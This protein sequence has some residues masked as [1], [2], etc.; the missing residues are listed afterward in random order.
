[1]QDTIQ[2]QT[3]FTSLMLAEG[4]PPC[5]S[6]YQ[7]IHDL[8]QQRKHDKTVF[9]NLV[10]EAENSLAQV[11]K[12]R[13]YKSIIENLESLY[14]DPSEVV[15]RQRCKGLAVLASGKHVYVYLLDYPVS[16][17]SIVA[18]SYHIKPLI[19][20]IQQSAPCY[21]LAL[22]S[23][24]FEIYSTDFHT[25]EKVALPDKVSMHLRELFDDFDNNMSVAAAGYGGSNPSFYAPV[26]KDEVVEKETEKFFRHVDKVINEHVVT[27]DNKQAFILTGLPKNQSLFRSLS[28][29]PTL[30]HTGIEQPFDSMSEEDILSQAKTIVKAVQDDHIQKLASSYSLA[31]AREEASSDPR[32][33]A[34]ALVERKVQLLFVD[35]NRSIPGQYDHKTGA[36]SFE[37][38]SNPCIDDLSD[39]FAQATYLQGGDVYLLDSESMPDRAVV[40][41]IF[42]Y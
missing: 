12:K 1:M 13:E 19:R 27:Q 28:E 4:E 32:I 17:R 18:Q 39:D 37:K 16:E 15:W 3:K 25:I 7:P 20:N 21:I 36:L 22:T 29:I 23:D 38:M 42:R 34:Q 26:S 41:A 8:P 2:I 33:I 35:E 9:K 6:L 14:E 5:I 10:V 31:H 24:S 11:Y 30:L 40:A